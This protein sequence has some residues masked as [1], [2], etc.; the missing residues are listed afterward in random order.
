[1]VLTEQNAPEA[2][3]PYILY[4]PYGCDSEPLVGW[5]TASNPTYTNGYLTGV[6]EETAV[7]IGSYVFNHQPDDSWGFSKVNSGFSFIDCYQVYLTAPTSMGMV[8]FDMQEMG[9]NGIT[10]ATNSSATVYDMLGRRVEPANGNAM[11][12]GIYVVRKGNGEIEKVS[13]K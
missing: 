11:K 13:M 12:K 7:P 5:G 9:I 6:Y 1:M 2:N 10:D 4:A 8:L 3:T